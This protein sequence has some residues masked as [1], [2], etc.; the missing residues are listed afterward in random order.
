MPSQRH[1]GK[2]GP[3]RG[4]HR[5][6]IL[7]I[8]GS[9]R[10]GGH[11]ELLL[12]SVLAGVRSEGS[13]TDKIILNDI[14]FKPCQ[15]CG[16]CSVSGVCVVIDGMSAVY[17][18][19]MSCDCVILSSP[20]FFG[21]VSAQVKMMIDRAN[22]LWIKGWKLK[23]KTGCPVKKGIFICTAGRAAAGYFRN[24]RKVVRLFFAVLGI[25]YSGELL[26]DG[27]DSAKRSSP[28]VKR[29]LKESFRMG[30]KLGHG[31]IRL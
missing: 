30:V 31:K 28:K 29:A 1:C 26:L 13:I 10:R 7:G 16:G 6:K 11:S 2:V 22:F 4:I 3:A 27:L 20:I 25:R 23:R 9:P 14:S 12:D 8:S 5:K 15:A 19:M 17:R 21:S 18:K 24:A